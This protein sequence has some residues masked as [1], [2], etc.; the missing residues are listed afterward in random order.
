MK[1]RIIKINDGLTIELEVCR[2]IIS[3]LFGAYDPFRNK[4]YSDIKLTNDLYLDFEEN[5][6][7]EFVCVSI[8]QNPGVYDEEIKAL[9]LDVGHIIKAVMNG[10]S[11]AFKNVISSRAFCAEEIAKDLGYRN[12]KKSAEW[13]CMDIIGGRSKGNPIPTA[14]RILKM[15]DDGDPEFYDMIPACPL[16]GKWADDISAKEVICDSLKL[17]ADELDE[18][19]KICEAL[20]IEEDLD[21]LKDQI[22]RHY[23]QAFQDQ[24]ISEIIDQCRSV[25]S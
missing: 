11:F 22:C 3:P 9:A 10:M 23:E 6:E 8:F 13:I 14:K 25:I 12:G 20:E 4:S 7:G 16:S 19:H 21:A 5:D 18:L 1:N 2:A 15:Y 17:N 24:C